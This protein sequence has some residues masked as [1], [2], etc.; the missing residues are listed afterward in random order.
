MKNYV[1]SSLD[2]ELD[3]S[4]AVFDE[5]GYVGYTDL[6][7][8]SDLSLL[9]DGVNTAVSNGKLNIGESDMLVNNDAIYA[10]DEIERICKLP[11][12]IK[13]ARILLGGGDIELQ[14]AKFNAKPKNDQGGGEVFWHQDYPFFPHSNFDLIACVIHLDDEEI[15]SG[16]LEFVPGSHKL[17]TLSHIN[18]EGV[19]AYECTDQNVINSSQ[20]ELFIA[21]RGWVTFHHGLALHRSAPKTIAKDR[22]FLV[23]QYRAIDAVQLAGVIWRCNGYQVHELSN[24]SRFARFPCGTKVELRG[25]GGRLYDQFNTLAPSHPTKY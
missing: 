5:L 9:L 7:S 1:F 6:L 22:R 2:D 17:G 19:F 15:G 21:K 4:K 10:H 18:S 24:R 8:N 13:V 16:S 25:I 23:F 14:H 20:T 12:L 11:Q 3:A